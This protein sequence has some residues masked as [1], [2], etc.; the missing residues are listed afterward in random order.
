MDYTTI[1]I[2]REQMKKIKLKALELD[3]TPKE[4]FIF[5]FAGIKY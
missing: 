3:K 1:Q 4:I 2:D 5:I